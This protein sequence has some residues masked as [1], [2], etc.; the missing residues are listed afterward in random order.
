[1]AKRETF[2]AA[3]YKLVLVFMS[4]HYKAFDLTTSQCEEDL[5]DEWVLNYL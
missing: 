5:G 1:M 2:S 3:I 4:S